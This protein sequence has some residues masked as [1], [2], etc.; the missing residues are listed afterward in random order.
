[1]LNWKLSSSLSCSWTEWSHGYL[2]DKNEMELLKK[3]KNRA[4]HFYIVPIH[5]QWDE[6]YIRTGWTNTKKWIIKL[7]GWHWLRLIYFWLNGIRWDH[8][9]LNSMICKTKNRRKTWWRNEYHADVYTDSHVFYKS[10]WNV[11]C[12]V[13]VNFDF[14]LVSLGFIFNLLKIR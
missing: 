4:R 7:C 8:F 1:M 3:K 9:I 12:K 13:F 2:A 6:W 11:E 10:L 5:T 14:F